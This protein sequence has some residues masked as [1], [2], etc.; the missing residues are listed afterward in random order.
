MSGIDWLGQIRQALATSC[1][2]RSLETLCVTS[3]TEIFWGGVPVHETLIQSQTQATAFRGTQYAGIA[4]LEIPDGAKVRSR[5]TTN[6]AGHFT[7]WAEPEDLM[8]YAREVVK[9]PA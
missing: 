5:K 8:L 4:I 7:L 9:L 3:D 6:Q 2:V 1:P